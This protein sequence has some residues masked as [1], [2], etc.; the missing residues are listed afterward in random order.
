M[1]KW[2]ILLA[3][4]TIGIVGY[5]GLNT[6]LQGSY[7]NAN[8]LFFLVN[9][10]RVS[11]KLSPFELDERLCTTA[12]LKAEDM[13]Q[14]NYFE[15][16]RGLFFGDLI[17]TYSP[18]AVFYGENLAVSNGN[19]QVIFD[20]WRKSESHNENMLRD[21][22]HSCVSLIFDTEERQSYVVQ[23]FSK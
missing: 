19:E 23:H 9:E 13:V 8:K 14:N 6:P 15:H 17:N 4:T 16:D 10:Y 12:K 22:T 2:I 11:E 21:F 5:S 18:T 20:A 3:L 7:L 1:R